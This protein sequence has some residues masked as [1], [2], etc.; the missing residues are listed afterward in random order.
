M[1]KGIKK[2]TLLFFLIAPGF[3]FAN[4]C[5]CCEDEIS[6]CYSVPKKATNIHIEIKFHQ[7][8]MTARLFAIEMCG[9]PSEISGNN[10]TIAGRIT[11]GKLKLVLCDGTKLASMF[12]LD[13]KND[14][15][16]HCIVTDAI[17]CQDNPTPAP[18]RSS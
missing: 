18:Y 9:K 1:K 6:Q 15:K 13:I 8:S 11:T 7:T 5:P 2:L 16:S 17:Y 14:Y 4:D 3:L 10:P 12:V